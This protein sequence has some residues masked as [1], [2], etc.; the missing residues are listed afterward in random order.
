M[1]ATFM[2][3]SERKKPGRDALAGL[4]PMIDT[5]FGE[6]GNYGVDAGPRTLVD[7]APSAS[8]I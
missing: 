3:I 1:L 4:R 8:R 2:G 7:H 5:S 6:I